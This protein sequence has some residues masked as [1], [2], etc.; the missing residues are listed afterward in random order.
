MLMYL[1]IVLAL[2]HPTAAKP[3]LRSES[4]IVRM[5]DTHEILLT[6][7]P[8]AARPIASVTKLMSGLL[9]SQHKNPT[10]ALITITEDD[11]DHRKWSR[12]RLRVGW[13]FPWSKLLEA[14]LGASDNRAMYAAVRGAGIP[15]AQFVAQMNAKA[16]TLGMLHTQF[17]DPAGVDPGNLST[18]RD[19]L[20][21][22]DAAAGSSTVCANTL[23]E[24]IQLTC[25][26]TKRSVRLT[27]PNRLAR[28]AAWDVVVGKTGYTIEAGRALVTRVTLHGRPVDMIFL[29][30]HEMASVFGDASRVRSWLT[31]HMPPRP[32]QISA[33]TT[34]R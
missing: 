18:A 9:L 14:A 17:V 24:T 7:N 16:Q 26:R 25:A 10:D 19:L 1:L 12:S 33:A 6:K 30:A 22:L 15:E 5:A 11:K 13:V 32:T 29:G 3:H 31:S 27:N 4:A 28:S 2:P 20:Q 21:L 8:D 23:H 34:V